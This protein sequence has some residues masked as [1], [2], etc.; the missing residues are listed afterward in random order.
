M[1]AALCIYTFVGC[2]QCLHDVACVVRIALCLW[3][4][5]IARVVYVVGFVF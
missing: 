1:L 2:R 3:V 4:C 5:S